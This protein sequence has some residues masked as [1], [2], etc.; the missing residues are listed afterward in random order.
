MHP[1]KRTWLTINLVGGIA[2]LGSYVHGLVTHPET[3]QMLW[4]TTPEE[5]KAV[6]NVTMLLAAAGYFLFSYVFVVRSDPDGFRVGAYGFGFVN[7]CYALVLLA[8][9][10][11]MPLTF[12]YFDTPSP[13]LWAVVRID[14][15]V[16]A[17]GSLGLVIAL[18]AM[19][20]RA[21]GVSGI[22]A[23]LGLLLFALQTAFLDPIVWP[24]FIPGT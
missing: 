24:Q 21:T 3:R 2:V 12:A 11:W 9:T 6:Y 18:F 5:L 1:Q 10:L 19:K 16:V 14:L 7:A 15:F 8:S 23:L 13:A 20:P 22:L 17:V 4:G